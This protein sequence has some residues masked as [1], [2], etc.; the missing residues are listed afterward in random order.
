MPRLPCR[1]QGFFVERGV[2]QEEA[3]SLLLLAAVT[4]QERTIEAFQN[5]RDEPR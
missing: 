4:A 3:V 2:R 1:W 5:A